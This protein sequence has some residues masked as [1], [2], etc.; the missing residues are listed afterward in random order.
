MITFPNAPQWEYRPV[1]IVK[2]ADTIK[3]IELYLHQLFPNQQVKE[4]TLCTCTGSTNYPLH[5]YYE[6]I[7]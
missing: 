4:P 1:D 6:V 5:I 7:S 2:D 3:E